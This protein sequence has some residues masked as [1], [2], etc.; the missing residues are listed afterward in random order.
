MRIAVTGANGFI[1]QQLCPYLQ[2]QLKADVITMTRSPSAPCNK[3]LSFS[4]SDEQLISELNQVDCLIHLAAKAHSNATA[5]DLERDNLNLSERIAKL[6]I[7]AK[8]PRVIYISSIKVNG[9]STQ[10]RSP[11]TADEIPQP[12]DAYGH[13]KLA[14][15]LILKKHLTNTRTELVIIRPPLVY[16][17]NNKGNLRSL[18]QL[19]RLGFPLPF[20]NIN[21]QRDLVSIENLCSLI[22]VTVTHPNAANQ[23]FLVSDGLTRNTQEIVQL[24]AK[25]QNKEVRFFKIPHWIFAAMKKY[26]PQINTRLTGNLQLDIAKTKS[27]L[28]WNPRD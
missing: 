8:I 23:T 19:I 13:S 15:E 4:T 12:D 11:F 17:G 2:E 26:K 24:L 18:E 10:G 28:S 7:A 22:G 1:G 9:D 16:G 6:A 21:N 14:S 20:A 27:L 5:A 25:T 3:A